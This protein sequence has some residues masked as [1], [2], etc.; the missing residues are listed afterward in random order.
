MEACPLV[1]GM[2]EEVQPEQERNEEKHPDPSPLSCSPVFHQS[3]TLAE[4][5]GTVNVEAWESLRAVDHV[6]QSRKG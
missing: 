1:A 6:V 2:A 4:Q 3:R 5:C